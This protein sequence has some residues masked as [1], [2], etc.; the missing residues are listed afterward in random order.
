MG[1]CDSQELIGYTQGKKRK[2]GSLCKYIYYF[3]YITVSNFKSKGRSVR[4]YLWDY[5]KVG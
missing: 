5:I 4:S 1:K 2:V 3:I